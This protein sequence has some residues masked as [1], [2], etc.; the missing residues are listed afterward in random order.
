MVIRCCN[1]VETLSFSKRHLAMI[2]QLRYEQVRDKQ[3]SCIL[4]DTYNI[5]QITNR[6][7]SRYHCYHLRVTGIKT[8]IHYLHYLGTSRIALDFASYGLH[9]NVVV[10]KR[11]NCHL[12]FKVFQ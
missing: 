11:L 9:A 5:L 12:R 4:N 7:K 8:F 1:N 10:D 6:R 2:L 3:A